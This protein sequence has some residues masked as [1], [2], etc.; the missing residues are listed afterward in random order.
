MAQQRFTAHK[1]EH[2][3]VLRRDIDVRVLNC[4]PS[5]CLLE[6]STRLAVGTVGHLRLII[7]GQEAVD[8]VE[9]VRCQPIGGAGSRC[10][11][12]VRFLALA[13]RSDEVTVRNVMANLPAAGGVSASIS[14]T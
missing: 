12:G 3:A 4:S 11:V 13:T 2:L 6:T 14:L 5:G 8:H 7:D 1:K 10:H 9:V